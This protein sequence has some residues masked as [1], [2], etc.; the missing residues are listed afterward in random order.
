MCYFDGCFVGN[1]VW[2]K[3][4]G[5]GVIKSCDKDADDILVVFEDDKKYPT[6][7]NFDYRGCI[8][9]GYGIQRL[10]YYKSRD[11]VITQDDLELKDTTNRYWLNDDGFNGEDSVDGD[12]YEIEM[13][14]DHFVRKVH[15]GEPKKVKL[16]DVLVK[17]D[18]VSTKGTEY[19]DICDYIYTNSDGIIEGFRL[20][21][22]E[23]KLQLNPLNIGK[24][25][26]HSEDFFNPHSILGFWGTTNR[27]EEAIRE[28]SGMVKN[29]TGRMEN[30][31]I[32][33]LKKLDR[34]SKLSKAG[35]QID[36]DLD[37]L[38]ERVA[39]LEKR[40]KKTK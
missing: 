25:I 12:S 32:N 7:V 33:L 22:E 39:K 2:D 40:G 15:R 3:I 28:L 21:K 29:L 11:I 16:T 30:R 6:V 37:K 8:D 24:Q 31:E 4:L 38:T 27:N 5:N 35:M 20:P 34:Y 10:Q 1:R 36:D 17:K 14:N 19:E 26:K 9:C 13:K 23:P 18:L